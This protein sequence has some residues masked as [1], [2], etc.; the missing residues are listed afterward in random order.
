MSIS[1][2]LESV[3]QKIHQITYNLD[4]YNDMIN[5]YCRMISDAQN[6]L[7]FLQNNLDIVDDSTK[8][9]I[10]DKIQTTEDNHVELNNE[11]ASYKENYK[12]KQSEL[13][14]LR[15]QEYYLNDSAVICAISDP[16]SAY[17]THKL[18]T[19]NN[20]DMIYGCE[21]KPISIMS[22]TNNLGKIICPDK[23]MIIINETYCNQCENEKINITILN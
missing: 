11:M 14:I 17:K 7:L 13:N 10:L 12:A 15:F 3:L 19:P 23:P 6:D 16:E 18:I 20:S 21:Y 2:Y 4:S 22:Y 8:I 1:D 5:E 9:D